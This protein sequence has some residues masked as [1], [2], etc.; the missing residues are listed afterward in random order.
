MTVDQIELFA[1]F[2]LLFVLL[3]WG[4]IRYDLVAFSALLIAAV[5]GLVP[6]EKVFTGFGHP[7]VVV[8]ALV[9]VVSRGLL[10]SGAIE[11]F[12][13]RILSTDR[14]TPQHIGLMAVLAA[15]LSAV[16]N[17]V[18]ALAL[19]MPLDIE[20]ARKAKRAISLSLMPLS[21][22]SILGGMITVIGTPPNIVIAQY[23]Q[24]VLGAPFRMFDFTPVGL[25]VTACGVL[26]VTLV[27]WRLLPNRANA[28]A[29]A[30][31]GDESLYV[32]ELRVA[33]G[34]K[35][36]GVTLA[37]LYPVADERDITLLGLIRNGRRLPGFARHEPIRQG[38]FI[39]VEGDPKAIETFMGK[40]GLDF[41]GSEKHEGGV[42]G[43]TLMLMEAIVPDN[44]R[45]VG[46]SANALRLIYRQG[47]TLLGVSRQGQRVHAQVRRLKIEPGDV[48]LLLGPRDR[49]DNAANWL[50]V[51][52]LEGKR[53]DVVQRQKAT[54]AI[55]AFALAICS[56]VA[57]LASL[58]VTLGICA[59]FYAAIGLL[60]GNE[61]Y[62]AVEWRV[63]V[64]LGSLIPLTQAFDDAGGAQ[65]IAS[66]ILHL[67][68]GTPAWVS[69]FVLMA[70]TMTL[71]DFLNN[72]ATA[73]LA[74]PVGI[75]IANA[76]HVNPDAFLMSVAVASSC[77]FLTPIG[78]KNNTIIMGPG[79]YHFGDY[80]RMGLPLEILVLA[81]SLP[82]LLITW[83]L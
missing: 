17:N 69:L 24:D 80:W 3:V 65:L 28:G 9:L 42:T 16:I 7:A 64:L 48:L 52:P 51:L 25:A 27:G 73:L 32:A 23:R 57:G 81:V 72:V 21:F 37:D 8:I 83:P 39:V 10:N 47:V 76:L 15:A 60:T 68:N 62:E 75:Q 58:E 36:E 14:S 40:A 66:G 78:H 38:D 61:V 79:G 11:K 70:V 45:I 22:A 67:T 74:A 53:T 41:A 50:G 6:D 34:S 77:A 13:S 44:T 31:Q 4:K 54:L 18:A 63:V 46:R 49:L 30:E 26:F 1:L 55:L 33:E 12:A 2:G 29:T 56:A 19:L 71:S 5:L 20:A 59:A 35:S 82:V 43:G